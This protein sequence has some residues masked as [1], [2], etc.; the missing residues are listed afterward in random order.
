V[1]A[2]SLTLAIDRETLR[3]ARKAAIDRDTSVNELVRRY[4]E[5]L[6]TEQDRRAAALEDLRE[7]FR[8]S[9]ARIGNATWTRDELH[10]R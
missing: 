5:Q 7:V 9:K 4:I 8:T 1:D 2:V 6:A 10:E 3:K